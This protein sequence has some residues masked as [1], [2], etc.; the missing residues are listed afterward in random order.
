LTSMRR[1]WWWWVLSAS[2][3]WAAGAC[4]PD[5]GARTDFRGSGLHG[6][7]AFISPAQ[8]SVEHDVS[9]E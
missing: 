8:S 5:K 7:P 1:G 9:Q 6:R 4:I 3:C 2:R